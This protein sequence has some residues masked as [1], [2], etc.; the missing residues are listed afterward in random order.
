MQDTVP[1]STKEGPSASELTGSARTVFRL[2]REEEAAL[3][4]AWFTF[5]TYM[6]SAHQ[7]KVPGGGMAYVIYSKY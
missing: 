7:Y 4:V 2:S 3:R 5:H 6:T 1:D